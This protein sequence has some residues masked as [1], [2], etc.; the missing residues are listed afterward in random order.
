MVTLAKYFSSLFVVEYNMN[1]LQFNKVHSKM[2]NIW[3]KVHPFGCNEFKCD[4][5]NYSLIANETGII[6]ALKDGLKEAQKLIRVLNM[7]LA[8]LSVA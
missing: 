3:E 7:E 8:T 2:E 4:L 6:E 5:A 1:G